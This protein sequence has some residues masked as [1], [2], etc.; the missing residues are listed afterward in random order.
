MTPGSLPVIL[1]LAKNLTLMTALFMS[2]R[3]FDFAQDDG[4]NLMQD[5]GRNITLDDRFV[6]PLIAVETVRVNLF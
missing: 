6:R 3:S 2:T 5:Y 1:S 4:G